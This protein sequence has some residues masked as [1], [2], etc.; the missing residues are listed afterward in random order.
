[1]LLNIGVIVVYVS[2]NNVRP[3]QLL[4]LF[5]ITGAWQNL[6]VSQE[7]KKESEKKKTYQDVNK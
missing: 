4:S 2:L 7:N 1:M 3:F 6:S 5:R